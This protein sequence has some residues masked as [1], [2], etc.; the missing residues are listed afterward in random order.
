MFAPSTV[1]ATGIAAALATPKL[2]PELSALNSFPII[3]VVSTLGSIAGSLL[4]PPDDEEVLKSFYRTVRPWGLWGPVHDLV[5]QDDP[6]FR[7]D[8]DF[9]RDASNIGVGL[10]GRD[11]IQVRPGVSVEKALEDVGGVQESPR[12]Y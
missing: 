2:L 7:T 5:V 10:V 8:A 11:G 9:K 1:M 12:P 4:T 3:L 6:G